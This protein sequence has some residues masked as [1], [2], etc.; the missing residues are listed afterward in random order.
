MLISH[1]HKFIF[2]KTE[3]TASSSLA[4]LLRNILK[5]SDELHPATPA[6]KRRLL[7][8]HGS[9]ENFSF[10]GQGGVVKR[11]WPARFGV[12]AHGT[13]A[14]VRGFLGERLFSGYRVITSER[15]PWDRQV[16]LYFH[17]AGKNGQEITPQAFD[18]A[19]RSR[20]Y[21]LLH[22]N[23]L[24]N[25]EIYTLDQRVCAHKVI[26]FEHLATD[27]ADTLDFLGIPAQGRELHHNRGEFRAGQRDYRPFYTEASRELIYRWY[28][29]EI[30]HF[31]YT[32]D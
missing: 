22:Y 11:L 15:N 3:K 21:N 23:R 14:D 12:H 27:L 30:D 7:A 18:R 13:A 24:R 19:M 6:V 8:A 20:L 1:R 25:W 29:N 17:R 5:E 4:R 2:L 9:L 26:R 31:G 28:R 10:Y 32:F 16:S